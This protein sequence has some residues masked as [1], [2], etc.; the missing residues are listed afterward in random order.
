MK[1]TRCILYVLNF[2]MTPFQVAGSN[3]KGHRDLH[4]LQLYTTEQAVNGRNMAV[5]Y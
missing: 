1:N 2:F 4:L 5:L 3:P